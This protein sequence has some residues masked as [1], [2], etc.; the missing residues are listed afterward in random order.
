MLEQNYSKDSKFTDFS[1]SS[2]ISEKYAITTWRT[3][4]SLIDLIQNPLDAS[5]DRLPTIKLCVGE[6]ASNKAR[7]W[8][9]LKAAKDLSETQKISAV[10][11]K[12]Y[13]Y[14]F[15]HE[16]LTLTGVSTKSSNAL[17]R[18]GLGEGLKL[19][20]LNI[21]RSGGKVT[22]ISKNRDTYWLATPVLKDNELLFEGKVINNKSKSTTFGSVT[23]IDISKIEPEQSK[24]IQNFFLDKS[25]DSISSY[26]LDFNSNPFIKDI[27]FRNAELT[28]LGVEP[29]RIYVMGLFIKQDEQIV[30]SYNLG[31]K[32]AINGRDRKEINLNKFNDALSDILPK[33]PTE[34]ISQILMKIS[35]G[36]KSL[37][38]CVLPQINLSDSQ[39]LRWRGAI[40]SFFDFTVGK[41]LFVS[42]TITESDKRLIES[43][44]FNCITISQ[45]VY[46]EFSEFLGVLYPNSVVLGSN[47]NNDYIIPFDFADI[48]LP[49]K[50][51]SIL[52]QLSE[53]L[54]SFIA[55]T[56]YILITEIYET[57]ASYFDV[58]NKISEVKFTPI[59]PDESAEQLSIATNQI[60]VS[61]N[62]PET[63]ATRV[64]LNLALI[65]YGSNGFMY[66]TLSQELLTKMVGA[67]VSP[68]L[69]T[70]SLPTVD[71]KTDLPRT[72][73]T[74]SL[75][76]KDERLI[77]LNEQIKNLKKHNITK[78][79]A[80]EILTDLNSNYRKSE[81][82][83]NLE[84]DKLLFC[85][86]G[87]VY[88]LDS[89]SLLLVQVD[90]AKKNSEIKDIIDD[91]LNSPTT[92]I[93]TS[94]DSYS[95]IGKDSSLTAFLNK[96]FEPN[97]DLAKFKSRFQSYKEKTQI[98][99]ESVI[100]LP[101]GLEHY[102]LYNNQTYYLP[103]SLINNHEFDRVDIK[104][105]NGL[106]SVD[107]SLS[108]YNDQL[109]LTF[110]SENKL[111]EYK[112]V[113]SQKIKF[114]NLSLTI[115]PSV[116]YIHSIRLIDLDLSVL[117]SSSSKDDAPISEINFQLKFIPTNI[118][119]DYGSQ[120]WNDPKRI[121]LDCLQNHIDASK[122]KFPQ[123][124]LFLANS[125]FKLTR[126]SLAKL[127]NFDADWQIIG[128]EISDEGK[129]FTTKNL[130]ILG[131]STKTTSDIGSFGEGLKM[132]SVALMRFELNVTISSLNWHASPTFYTKTIE[133]YETNAIKEFTLLGY[134]LDIKEDSR[135][136]SAT[137]VSLIPLGV[138]QE[139][140]SQS[141]REKIQ[142]FLNCE[143]KSNF[144]RELSG[145]FELRNDLKRNYYSL[146]D[147]VLQDK[148]PFTDGA[149]TVHPSK[150]GK[151]YVKN[152]L[153]KTDFTIESPLLFGYKFMS[154]L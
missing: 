105:K 54:K 136:G 3:V 4:Q 154:I 122:G 137:L 48:S 64:L 96:I 116:I 36:L 135:Q 114:N 144:W 112:N 26:I 33:V 13:G 47:L 139:T 107:I 80:E 68:L 75:K 24:V 30:L 17:K 53:N 46:E 129:G 22:L 77:K 130:Q 121:I 73:Y 69:L 35:H 15:S 39:V 70:I 92:T 63:A 138:N 99:A 12:D 94:D 86:N 34:Q 65:K 49:N 152:L 21:V 20:V 117:Y 32:W 124:E 134:N 132:L 11:I 87:E 27:I 97:E 8:I 148:S 29:G 41:D 103:I 115:Y 93:N 74:D 76:I 120:I 111:T 149:I 131:N 108:Y 56:R 61:P 59:N 101:Q 126:C 104:F 95:K 85:W 60:R 58:I 79:E 50:P 31:D 78:E 6:R 45:N 7:K 150:S 42:S 142:S 37:E 133:D 55:E 84:I 88:Q 146:N 2:L 5:P 23:V 19:S 9:D 106:S 38:L 62:I 72:K 52:P 128:F 102:T 100:V 98:N 109:D 25:Q 66:G 147:L 125:N 90:K 71:I 141:D 91:N 89:M 82:I 119:I 18:G 57:T 40:E 118:S 110:T 14:G 1:N 10:M 140:I 83:C 81:V 113:F 151:V 67:V 153:I 28:S 127:T 16:L 51:A 145:I 44:Q 123:I 43:K 143:D